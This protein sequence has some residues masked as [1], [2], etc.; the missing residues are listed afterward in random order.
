MRRC[1]LLFCLPAEACAT[2]P[3]ATPTRGGWRRQSSTHRSLGERRRFQFGPQS[4][5]RWCFAWISDESEMTLCRRSSWFACLGG[6]IVVIISNHN[7]SIF[8]GHSIGN[9]TTL[10]FWLRFCWHS[11]HKFCQK[12]WIQN[13]IVLGVFCCWCWLC[14]T[15]RLEGCAND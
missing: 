7:F 15:F 8:W 14:K 1:C 5:P 12:R 3:S 6:A 11:L 9:D 4:C 10:K 13:L 2:E